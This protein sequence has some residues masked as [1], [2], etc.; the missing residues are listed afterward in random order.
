MHRRVALVI[1]AV[2]LI[3]AMAVYASDVESDMSMEVERAAA[4]RPAP[5]AARPAPPRVVARVAVAH[6]QAKAK[7]VIHAKAAVKHL[8]KASHHAG[9]KDHHHAGKKHHH[10]H[11]HHHKGAHKHKHKKDNRKIDRILARLARRARAKAKK[12][13]LTGKALR[14]FLRKQMMKARSRLRPTLARNLKDRHLRRLARKVK[15]TQSRKSISKLQ[16]A[17]KRKNAGS[18]KLNVKHHSITVHPRNPKPKKIKVHKESPTDKNYVKHLRQTRQEYMDRI[19]RAERQLHTESHNR[20]AGRVNDWPIKYGLIDP[21]DSSK[22]A[23]AKELYD[24]LKPF[25]KDAKSVKQDDL[26][27]GKQQ[28]KTMEALR[29]EVRDKLDK[30]RASPLLPKIFRFIE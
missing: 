5:P 2:M 12:L 9:K 22:A 16:A 3:M 19:R 1:M 4:A 25:L 13:G 30:A 15:R 8:V 27:D 10:H 24:E 29:W 23:A 17:L 6:H 11:H 21:P 26:I 20:L 7:A 18:V 28:L 14:R